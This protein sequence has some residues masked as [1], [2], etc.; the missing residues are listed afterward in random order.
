MLFFNPATPY[1]VE[2][3]EDFYMPKVVHYRFGH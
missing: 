2:K 1:Q 3:E